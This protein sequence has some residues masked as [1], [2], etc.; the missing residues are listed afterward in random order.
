MWRAVERYGVWPPEGIA[1]DCNDEQNHPFD[2]PRLPF[3]YIFTLGMVPFIFGSGRLARI[4]AV[5]RRD[6]VTIVEHQK[7]ARVK[8]NMI[9]SRFENIHNGRRRQKYLRAMVMDID[10][11]RKGVVFFDEVFDSKIS[12]CPVLS[13]KEVSSVQG[14]AYCA[15]KVTTKKG[16]KRG[17]KNRRSRKT[18]NGNVEVDS[19]ENLLLF[20]KIMTR[21]ARRAERFKL[22]QGEWE[23]DCLDGE[24]L[25]EFAAV[26]AEREALRDKENEFRRV[27]ERTHQNATTTNASLRNIR[28]KVRKR[29]YGRIK[30]NEN[31]RVW[32]TL[33]SSLQTKNKNIGKAFA[34]FSRH[35]RTYFIRRSMKSRADEEKRATPT[36]I[37]YREEEGRVLELL[38]EAVSKAGF[39][40][41]DFELES[42]VKAVK[43]LE[44]TEDYQGLITIDRVEFRQ[45]L[46]RLS[47]A[48]CE[49][50]GWPRTAHAREFCHKEDGSE[51]SKPGARELH[52]RCFAQRPI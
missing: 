32:E 19:R 50:L 11:D 41:E 43:M 14:P 4:S 12:R 35:S 51:I 8:A 45:I 46:A 6:L 23:G 28:E 52:S 16:T 38:H 47:L 21:F 5:W 44:S 26:L 20:Q 1:V 27:W 48:H 10:H 39:S 22:A 29:E 42:A 31:T 30:K 13:T 33:I 25:A 49:D 15:S 34:E 7:R 24:G 37:V 17:S 2:C 3:L 36:G 40:A 18:Y 9:I